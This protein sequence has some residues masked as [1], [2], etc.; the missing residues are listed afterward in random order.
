MTTRIPTVQI[1]GIPTALLSRAETSNYYMSIVDQHRRSP[2]GRPVLASSMNGQTIYE[3]RQRPEVRDLFLGMDINSMD[4][5]PAVLFSRRWPR[6]IPERVATT[7]LIHDMAA[8]GLETGLRHFFLGGKPG[9]A[10]RAA[11]ALSHAHPG[12]ITAGVH[13][14][15]VSEEQLS[16]MAAGI[17]A[18]GADILW[19]CMGAPR[20][21][22]VALKLAEMDTGVA[23]IKTGGGVLDFTCGDRPRAPAWVQAVGLEWAFRFALEPKR[24]GLRYLV[25]NPVAL[26][27]LATMR[28][29]YTEQDLA[30]EGG[31]A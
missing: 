17:R 5:Q 23:I 7:D 2:L 31:G 27:T 28:P 6:S 11:A 14:G 4:G 16:E 18:S 29:S 30:L 25:S 22:Q 1:A 26:L 19:L 15:Y 9:V 8:A 10:A 12:M 24:L 3:V 13:H 20:E 21:Q